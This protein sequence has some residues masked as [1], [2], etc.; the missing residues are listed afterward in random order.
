ME[1]FAPASHRS[2]GGGI[3]VGGDV[4]QLDGVAGWASQQDAPDG[5]GRQRGCGLGDK[6]NEAEG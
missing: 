3:L 4:E 6:L 2:M 5:G 1:G